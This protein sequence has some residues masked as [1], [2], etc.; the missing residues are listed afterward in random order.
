MRCI[1]DLTGTAVVFIATLTALLAGCAQR[2]PPAGRSAFD[3]S[4]VASNALP[5]VVITAR[6]P[7]TIVLTERATEGVP[8]R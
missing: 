6:R 1:N 7:K 4:T 2:D 5:E 8:P 3:A